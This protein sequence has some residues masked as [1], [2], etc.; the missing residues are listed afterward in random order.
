LQVALHLA[1]FADG[2]RVLTELAVFRRDGEWVQAV[3]AWRHDE[4]PVEGWPYLADLLGLRG[5]RE[6]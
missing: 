4:G 2:R 5:G 3:P 1:R 6:P